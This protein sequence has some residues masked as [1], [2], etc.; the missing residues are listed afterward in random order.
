MQTKYF[1]T[2]GVMIDCS[3]NA[4]MTV[5]QLKKYMSI[6]SKMGYNQLHLYMEDTYEIDNTPF[7]GYLRGRYSQSELKELD[8]FAYGLGIELVPNIQTLGHLTG[9]LMWD[10]SLRDAENILLVG[11]ERSYKL[12]E[13]MF[14]S[15]R[16]CFRTDKIHIGMDEA[17]MLGRGRYYDE[18]G[19]QNRFDILLGHLNRVCEL[20]D[21]YDFKPMMWSDM[22]YCLANGGSYYTPSEKFDKSIKEKIPQNLSLVYWDYYSTD[23]KRYEGMI[24]GH[25]QLTDN[26]IF[27]GGAWKWVGFAPDNSYSIKATKAALTSCIKTG[28]RSTLIT[29]WGDNGAEC[30]S[31]A[32]LP[33]LCYAACLTQGITKIADIKRKFYEWV[34]CRY[35]DFMLLDKCN[36]L[37]KLD[38]VVNPSKYIL[39]TDCF[40]STLNSTVRDGDNE[41]YAAISRKLRF[42]SKRVGEYSYLF[43]TLSKL[44]A[45]LSIK[46]E[47][48]NKSRAAY[49]SNDKSQLDS[50]IADYK[51]LIK[52]TDAFY[53]AFRNQWYYENKP[54]GFDVQDTR[55]GGLIGRMKS[56]LDRLVDY[57]DGKIENIPELEEELLVISNDDLCYN[58]WVRAVTPNLFGYLY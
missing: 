34:G 11:D 28:L 4:V 30:S 19:P 17:Y 49:N 33:T 20:A 41:R 18:H 6:L 14:S 44:C 26:L 46:A 47:L 9:Y 42:A 56:C 50:V 51:K 22:F 12:I 54:H 5:E 13:N 40:M 10:C 35:D 29:A 53:K 57:R 39:Y 27:A 52:L 32:I 3:R 16:K 48:C 55:L 37:Q 36:K 7:F 24:K 38:K 25:R 31:Y 1:D 58:D 8:D 43:D 15:L 23:K 21:K 45:V 2:L